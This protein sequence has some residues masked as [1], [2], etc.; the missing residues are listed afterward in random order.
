MYLIWLSR[1]QTILA[2]S[3]DLRMTSMSLLNSDRHLECYSKEHS[4]ADPSP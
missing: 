1:E 2:I 4:S 3:I